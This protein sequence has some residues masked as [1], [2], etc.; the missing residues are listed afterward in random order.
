MKCEIGILDLGLNNIK[1]VVSF[2]KKFGNVI[3]IEKI[4]E[5][6]IYNDL[7]L[8]VIPGNGNFLSGHL[9]Y[10]NRVDFPKETLSNTSARRIKPSIF[11]ML[12]K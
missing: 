6:K 4:N 5:N 10:L 2:F 3:I 9:I 11:M 7:D 12:V 1:S 8:L